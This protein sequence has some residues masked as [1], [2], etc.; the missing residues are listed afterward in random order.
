MIS[1]AYICTNMCTT[2]LLD[3]ILINMSCPNRSMMFERSKFSGWDGTYKV[4]TGSE[5]K[6]K[7]VEG[8]CNIVQVHATLKPF[9]ERLTT[10][11]HINNIPGNCFMRETFSAISFWFAWVLG[12]SSC[13]TIWPYPLHQITSKES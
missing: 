9:A 11:C 6:S 12:S 3:E 1:Y 7:L 4:L 8:L 10:F 2:L 5:L 13:V